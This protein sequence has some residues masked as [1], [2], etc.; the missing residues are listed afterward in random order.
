M[1]LVGNLVLAVSLALGVLSAGT[2]YVRPDW[3]SPPAAGEQPLTLNADAGLVVLDDDLSLVV[4]QQ[5]GPM[6]AAQHVLSPLGR[7][8]PLTLTLEAASFARDPFA[9]RALS[10]LPGQE[11]AKAKYDPASGAVLLG[12]GAR[13][14]LFRKNDKLSVEVIRALKANHLKDASEEPVVRDVIVQEF[15]LW[16][17]PGR[18]L[19]LAAILGLLVAAGLLRSASRRDATVAGLARAAEGPE[20]ALDEIQA[21][22]EKLRRDRFTLGAEQERLQAILESLSVVQKTHMPAFVEARPLLVARLGL[23]GYAEL[24]DRYA[25]AER[26]IYRAWSAAADGALEE[27]EVCLEAAAELLEES[28]GRLTVP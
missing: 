5:R 12:K 24:M 19:F 26:Q 21:T 23:G 7:A 10:R 1:K 28:Q 17:W 3:Q 18:W 22:V 9:Y 14:P 15:S 27:A 4:A 13:A 20:L 16:R 6:L 2:A 8:P 25:A 11:L